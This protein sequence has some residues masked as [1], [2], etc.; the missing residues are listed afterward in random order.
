MPVKMCEF[1]KYYDPF[2]PE[3]DYCGPEGTAIEKCIPPKILGIDTNIACWEH[4]QGYKH[5]EGKS[6]VDKKYRD[7]MYK[8]ILEATSPLSPRRYMALTIALRRY[9]IVKWFGKDSYNGA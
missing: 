6:E 1:P 5:K 4:D 7:R 8:I 9:H 3:K 2:D